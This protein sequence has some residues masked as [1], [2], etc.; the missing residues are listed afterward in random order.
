MVEVELNQMLAEISGARLV[1]LDIGGEAVS[2]KQL[3]VK[4]GLH[5]DDLGAIFINKK[6]GL[7]D[8]VIR[9][10]DFVQLYPFMEGG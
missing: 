3:I 7:F 10:G 6:W 4:L 8:S 1:K 2:L 9:D 5:E